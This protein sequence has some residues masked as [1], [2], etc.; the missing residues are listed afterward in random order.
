MSEPVTAVALDTRKS[1]VQTEETLEGT[2]ENLG[3]SSA[4]SDGS[5]DGLEYTI[6]TPEIVYDMYPAEPIDELAQQYQKIENAQ[7]AYARLLYGSENSTKA[8]VFD[9]KKLMQGQDEKGQTFDLKTH[10][11]KLTGSSTIAPTAEIQQYFDSYDTAMRYVARPACS[12]QEYVRLWHGPTSDLAQVQGDNRQ[13][14]SPVAD[15]GKKGAIYPTRIYKL[16]QGP[17]PDPGAAV[18]NIGPAPDYA[19]VDT[20]KFAAEDMAQT[21]QNWDERLEQ[22]RKILISAEGYKHPQG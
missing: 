7:L 21:R 11:D 22:Y 5:A 12:L 10:A 8:A 17:G 19:P 3:A 18:T 14:Y 20:F 16:R 1:I 2:D 9:W 13:Y 6:L 15:S 4:P